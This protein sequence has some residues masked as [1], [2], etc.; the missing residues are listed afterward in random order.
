VVYWIQTNKQTKK[1][2]YK[3]LGAR[4]DPPPP[5]PDMESQTTMGASNQSFDPW[6]PHYCGK[7]LP[8]VQA[9]IFI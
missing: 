1:S 7:T 3:E 5:H 6:I 2:I 4:S 8:V 9:D